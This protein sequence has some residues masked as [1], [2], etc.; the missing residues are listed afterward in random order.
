LKLFTIIQIVVKCITFAEIVYTESVYVR[1][2][3]GACDGIYC[4]SSSWT[5]G[6]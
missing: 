4:R 5:T 1:T 2:K 3:R 6:I